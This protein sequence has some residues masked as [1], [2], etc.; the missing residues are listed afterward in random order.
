MKA[1]YGYV[2]AIRLG[3]GTVLGVVLSII[4]QMACVILR[5]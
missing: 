1:E 3:L 2:A 4:S 5:K